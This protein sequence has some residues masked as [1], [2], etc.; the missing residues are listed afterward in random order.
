ML[1]CHYQQSP[2]TIPFQCCLSSPAV[3]RSDWQCRPSICRGHPPDVPKNPTARVHP[4]FCYFA[5][6]NT[7]LLI[8]F[9]EGIASLWLLP[10]R[11]RG[12]SWSNHRGGRTES[13]N[14]THGH[15]SNQVRSFINIL[16]CWF[17]ST[18][19]VNHLQKQQQR[20]CLSEHKPNRNRKRA[21]WWIYFRMTT[22]FPSLH[23]QL[24]S[25][26]YIIATL[27]YSLCK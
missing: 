11:P 14:S 3:C 7:F 5:N 15:L 8:V 25:L 4:F 27:L 24:P 16:Q 21:F 23:Q 17:L 20:R 19:A 2:I 6:L 26:N 9:P 12:H 10:T 22:L 1:S 18:E 13:I